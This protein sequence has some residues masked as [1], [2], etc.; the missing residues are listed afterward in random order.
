MLVARDEN[1]QPFSEE[2]LFGNC[3][4]ML[5]AGEDTTANSL[6]WAVHLLCEHPE[7]VASLRTELDG[8]LGTA[9]V[10][11]SLE[12][13]N[14]L[15]RANAVSSESMRLKPV[16][17]LNF[18]NTLR[19]TVVGDIEIPA[20]TNVM[21][22]GRVAAMD[23]RNFA[24]AARFRPGRWLDAGNG[25]AHEPG[26]S[27]PFG[28]GPRIC[29]GRSLALVEMRLVLAMLYKNFDVSRV[30]AADDVSERYSF[31]VM[32]TDLKVRLTRRAA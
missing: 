10:P 29:P 21:I 11:R 17:P 25:G 13:T 32:P 4:S 5:L 27:Q 16:A 24:E 6:A 2:I 15:Q 8:T 31:T 28:S 19:D 20:G 18:M 23:D 3:M 12:E 22:I 7:E 9:T 30:G 1:G 26:A 14:S